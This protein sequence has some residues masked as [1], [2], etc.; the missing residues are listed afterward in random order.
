[1]RS[2][3]TAVEKENTDNRKSLSQSMLLRLRRHQRSVLV[4]LK[5]RL[6]YG[7]QEN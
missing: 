1:L 2:E 6:A 4:E 3:A 5:G 7:E